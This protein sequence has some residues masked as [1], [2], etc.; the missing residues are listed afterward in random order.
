M[1]AGHMVVSGSLNSLSISPRCGAVLWAQVGQ[2]QVSEAGRA[3][4]A[5]AAC[6]L[7]YR[8]V[9]GPMWAQRTLERLGPTLHFSRSSEIR[10][11]DNCTPEFHSHL[12][13]LQ[14][15]RDWDS[16][17]GVVGKHGGLCEMA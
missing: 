2:R 15:S 5:L 16:F 13:Y 4:Y 10:H 3:G 7:Y 1:C 9:S 11:T 8:P 17:P 6:R 12:C 14:L